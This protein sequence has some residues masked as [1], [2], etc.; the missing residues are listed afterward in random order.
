MKVFKTISAYVIAATLGVAGLGV[1]GLGMMG[2]AAVAQE[3]K[4]R[5]DTLKATH[6]AWEVRC[7]SENCL[8]R[9][10]AKNE[11]GTPV[12]EVNILKLEEPRELE[13]GDNVV[14]IAIIVTPLN[15]ILPSGVGIRVDDKNVAQMGFLVCTVVGCESRPPLRQS[16]IESFNAGGTLGLLTAVP[17]TDGPKVIKVD[18][19]LTG[20]TAAFA[21]L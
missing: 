13:D 21:E 8:I 6:G 12:V 5:A 19:S 9:Q 4:E 18:M 3:A 17:T 7:A 16:T 15:V 20:F 1:A 14:A 11:Q 10:V 2:S